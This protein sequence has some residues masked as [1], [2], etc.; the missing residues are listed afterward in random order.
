MTGSYAERGRARNRRAL[1][2]VPFLLTAVTACGS[3][4]PGSG[5]YLRGRVFDGATLGPV[6]KAELT[7]ISGDG[8]AHAT[9]ADDGTFSIG[10]IEPSSSYRVAAKANGMEAF[11]FTGIGLPAIDPT[12]SDRTR[13]VIGDVALYKAS[14][15]SP[16]FKIMVESSD[17]RLPAKVASVDFMP[18]Q[19]GTDPSKTVTALTPPAG[20]VVGAFAEPRGATMPNDMH[21]E[22]VAL[23]AWASNGSASIPEGALTWGATYNVKVDA[24]PDFTPVTFQ[25]TPVKS[26]DISVVVPTT[27]KF[28]NQLPQQTQQ[29]FSGRIYNGATLEALKSYKISLEYFDRMIEGSVDADGRYVVGPLLANADYTIIVEANG[30]RSFLSHNAKLATSGTSQLSSLYYDAFLYPEGVEAPAVRAKFVLQGDTQLPSG[31]VRFSPK[32]GSSLFDEDSETPAGVGRQIW[33]NDADLQQRAITKDFMDGGL[34]VAAGQFVLGVEY[35]VSV[36]GV[37]NYAALSGGSFRAGIDTNPT[38]TLAPLTETPL[39]VISMSNE[40][41]SLSSD[42]SIQ[43][44][45]NHDIKLSPKM[46]QDVALR[47]LNDGFSINSPDK[48]M[49]STVN[50]LVDFGDVPQAPAGY[51][52]VTWDISGNTLTLKWERERG[53][54]TTDVMDPIIDVT[55]SDLSSI[56]LYTGT[57]STSPTVRLDT[58]LGVSSLTVQ[59]VAQ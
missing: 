2:L 11:E 16:G 26:S 51:R 58:L 30:F 32:G 43:I 45:F 17:G 56:T 54:K 22:S 18:A 10:P 40:G 53:L 12:A 50:T 29:Y 25:L 46:D 1:A 28:P 44:R 9:S 3:D 57:L 52:G 49:D 36:Y 55:Y 38:F 47:A 7:L 6:G 34:D 14:M 33:T 20:A 21:A 41:T 13:T 39:D 15:K 31:T 23:H 19:V 35:A 5:Y 27:A 48:N 8:T 37:P 59:M 4:S 42:G 24:G